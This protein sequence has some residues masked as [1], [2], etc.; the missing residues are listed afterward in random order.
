MAIGTEAVSAAERVALAVAREFPQSVFFAGK[1]IFQR[2]KWYHRLL[3]NETALAVGGQDDGDHAN[4]SA[5]RDLK[6][7]QRLLHLATIRRCLKLKRCPLHALVRHRPTFSCLREGRSQASSR[8][9]TNDAAD[10]ATDTNKD[11]GTDLLRGCHVGHSR[12]WP[13]TTKGCP[14]HGVKESHGT[15]C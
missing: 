3:H 1:M 2:E 14:S 7:L 10:N 11:N 8:P 12:L 4:W 15:A 9:G 13:K 6:S 5:G